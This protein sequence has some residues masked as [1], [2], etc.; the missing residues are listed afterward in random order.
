MLV[1]FIIVSS[2]SSEQPEAQE[3]ADQISFRVIIICH[4]LGYGIYGNMLDG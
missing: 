3:P 2:L 1:D 4:I